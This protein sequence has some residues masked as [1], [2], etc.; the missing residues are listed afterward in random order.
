MIK[1]LGYNIGLS[2][3]RVWNY[4]NPFDYSY[5]LEKGENALAL[6]IPRGGRY[7]VYWDNIYVNKFVVDG[8]YVSGLDSID[9]HKLTTGIKVENPIH[10]EDSVN[11]KVQA[12]KLKYA[13]REAID[14]VIAGI[15][16][17][18]IVHGVNL[19]S[20]DLVQIVEKGGDCGYPLPIKN[21]KD[22]VVSPL[23]AAGTAHTQLDIDAKNDDLVTSHYDV[24]NATGANWTTYAK[25][26][27]Q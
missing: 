20:T 24:V 13:G 6:T 27:N 26:F 18:F 2:T 5:Y 19:K 3:V 16:Y 1:I 10:P 14:S 9:T 15:P 17:R 8:P 12:L 7:S 11:M 4:E 21:D 23:F 22:V 25:S